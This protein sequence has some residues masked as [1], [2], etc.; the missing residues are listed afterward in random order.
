MRYDIFLFEAGIVVLSAALFYMGIVLR[1]LTGIVKE[2]QAIWIMPVIAGA[3]LLVSLASHAYA[4]FALFPAVEAKIKLLSSD[5]AL[6]S[7]DKL[8]AV[9]AGIAAIKEQVMN[10]KI[11]SFSCFFLASLLLSISTAIYM[12][13]ISK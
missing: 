4:N 6:L 9:K 11:I 13:W 7:A 2:K 5:G 3:V 12:K 10:L 8:L 1:K